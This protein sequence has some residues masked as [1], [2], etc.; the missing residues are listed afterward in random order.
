MK[1]NETNTQAKSEAWEAF[2]KSGKVSDYLIYNG[3]S[4]AEIYGN[5]KNKGNSDF[6]D[7]LWRE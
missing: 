5:D 3:K 6:A 2:K 4:E 1:A 7:S